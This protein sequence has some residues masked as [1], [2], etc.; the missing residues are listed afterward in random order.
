MTEIIKE[1]TREIDCGQIPESIEI[2]IDPAT[3]KL[4][5]FHR[6]TLEPIE[7]TA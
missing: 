1:I 4:V 5:Q 3:G 6:E 7:K 2:E